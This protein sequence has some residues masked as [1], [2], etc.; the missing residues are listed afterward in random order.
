MRLPTIVD[1]PLPRI[2]SPILE[3]SKR[4]QVFVAWT[5]PITEGERRAVVGGVQDV[6]DMTGYDSTITLHGTRSFGKG[7]A[8][9]YQQLALT[10]PVRDLGYGPQVQSGPP[11]W[12]PYNE[13]SRYSQKH[14]VVV[15]IDHDMTTGLLNFTLGAADVGCGFV[16][17]VARFREITN[18]VLRFSVMKR[19]AR[20]ELGHVFDIP[21]RKRVF[22]DHCGNQ[23]CGMNW[24]T[25]VDHFIREEKDGVTFCQQCVGDLENIPRVKD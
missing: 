2:G 13:T 23:P 6:L 3:D 9:W 21:F 25:G 4:I 7:N 16:V 12:G 1:K 14:L 11:V 19:L 24:C 5:K 10:N 15:I 22:G 8:D 20:H 17:S 18:T